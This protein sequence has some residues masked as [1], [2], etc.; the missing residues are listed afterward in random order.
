MTYEERKEAFEGMVKKMRINY[1]A[2]EGGAMTKQELAD[3]L[4]LEVYLFVNYCILEGE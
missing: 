2:C 4:I 3:K 1:N